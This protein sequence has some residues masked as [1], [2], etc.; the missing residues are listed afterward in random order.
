M[1]ILERKHSVA[2]VSL[3][4]VCNF[5]CDYCISGSYNQEIQTNEDGSVKVFKDPRL[6]DKGQVDLQLA[7]KYGLSMGTMTPEEH[8]RMLKE[9]NLGHS[10]GD[11]LDHNKFIDFCR[12]RLH[13]WVIQVTG[14]EPL[15]V[16]KAD[17]FIL[18]LSKTHKIILLSNISRLSKNMSIL[19][20]PND[21]LFFRVG[22]HPESYPI[23]GY[24]KNIKILEDNNRDYIVNYV[25]HPRHIENGMAKA[26]VDFL[27]D[28]DIPHEV[29]RFEGNWGGKHYPFAEISDRERELLSSHSID[30]NFTRDVNTPGTTFMAIQPNGH[31]YQC[32]IKGRYLGSIYDGRFLSN[33]KKALPECFGEMNKC[34]SVVAQEHIFHNIGWGD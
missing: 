22:F 5:T 14:G 9:N 2:E 23:E 12:T 6:N 11:F 29:T 3:S 8:D 21:R 19:N 32:S 1:E 15:I 30:N 13:D 16:P 17:E 20:I 4:N 27:I 24:L 18:E 7:R 31:I 33:N 26:Y 34:P 28:N 25:L 10:Q